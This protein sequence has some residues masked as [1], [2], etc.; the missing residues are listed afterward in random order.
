MHACFDFRLS[1]SPQVSLCWYVFS[2][3]GAAASIGSSNFSVRFLNGF[4]ELHIIGID[5]IDALIIIYMAVQQYIQGRM[6]SSD[7]VNVSQWY[8]Q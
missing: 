1:D 7:H 2:L 3:Q 5:N 4:F 6:C 8:W